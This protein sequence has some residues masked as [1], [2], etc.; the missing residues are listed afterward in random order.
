MNEN[1]PAKA[2]RTYADLVGL[3]FAELYRAEEKFP[4]FPADPVHAIAIVAEELGEL[5]RAV[6]RWTYE[7][8]GLEGG[9]GVGQE[10][11]QTAA[12]ALRF[13]FNLDRFAPRPASGCLP[14][15]VG[16]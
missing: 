14:R 9:G 3:V 4:G 2:T 1:T 8:G 5:T 7:G 10:A 12:M 11:V 16:L 15:R 13:L 6:L